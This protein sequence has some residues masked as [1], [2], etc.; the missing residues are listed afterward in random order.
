MLCAEHTATWSEVEHDLYEENSYIFGVELDLL[1]GHECYYCKTIENDVEYY[2]YF[3][4]DIC[5]A[6]DQY[7]EMLKESYSWQ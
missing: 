1:N 3:D 6:I 7:N 5:A 4:G 2:E